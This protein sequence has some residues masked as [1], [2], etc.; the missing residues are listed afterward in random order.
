MVVVDRNEVPE[1]PSSAGEGSYW[2]GDE[3]AVEILRALRRF[4]HADQQMRRRISAG[5]DMNETD[6][7]ALRIVIAAER[8]GSGR[9]HV[10]PRDL[11]T[12]LGISTAS[13]TKLLDRLTTSGHLVRAPHP[14]DRRSLVVMATEHAHT[15]VRE[16][17][18][19]MHDRMLEIAQEVPPEARAGV[20]GFLRAMTR[21]LDEQLPPE[22]LTARR[23]RR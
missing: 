4:R 9:P 2:W 14:T 12:E 20:L 15:E 7:Q 6:V 21:L 1:V 3:P 16:R 19:R 13:T 11:A 10:T 18:T 23:T 22:P 8:A 5:M 17:L